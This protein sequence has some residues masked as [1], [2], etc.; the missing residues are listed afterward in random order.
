MLFLKTL[1][2]YITVFVVKIFFLQPVQAQTPSSTISFEERV[3]DFGT[4]SEKKGKVSHKFIFHNKG[5]TPVVISDIYSGCGCIGK[6]VSKAPVKPGGK[7]EVVIT[8][9][10]EYKS[11]F[12][13]KEVV[14]YS[15]NGENYNRIWV[16]GKITPA[17]HPIE[18]DYPYNF[19]EG[20]NLRLKVMAFGYLKPG[21]TKQMEL[22]YAN[23]TNQEMTLNFVIRDNKQG[24]K[25][26]NPGKIPANA[27]G[28]ISFSYTMP[29]PS[30]DDVYFTLYPY[31]NKKKTKETLEVKILNERKQ[32]K[33]NR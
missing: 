24:L 30:V 8:F 29:L 17:E 5:T 20:L 33:N 26:S 12:F 31:V 13:S 14:V 23:S 1:R 6:A 21:E 2:R 32:N 22:H 7:G 3:Y 18:D 27:K 11:G 25:F 28:V 15:N 4:I 9:N 16:E 19:G 10:P